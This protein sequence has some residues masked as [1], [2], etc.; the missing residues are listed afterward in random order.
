MTE[1]IPPNQTV[2]VGSIWDMRDEPDG[3]GGWMGLF[4]VAKIEGDIAFGSEEE[5]IESA[6]LANNYLKL[7]QKEAEKIRAEMKEYHK[8]TI[9]PIKGPNGKIMQVGSIW[10]HNYGTPGDNHT[11]I[12]AS[13]GDDTAWSDSEY[14]G[15]GTNASELFE[16]GHEI[17]IEELPAYYSMRKRK[18]L[19]EEIKKAENKHPTEIDVYRVYNNGLLV[20][21]KVTTEGKS[22]NTLPKI[23]YNDREAT[24]EEKEEIERS[25]REFREWAMRERALAAESPHKIMQKMIKKPARISVPLL[26]KAVI[27]AIP[28]NNTAIINKE[29]T[30]KAVNES[31]NKH[32]HNKERLRA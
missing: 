12:V 23:T 5:G 4:E 9:Q 15:W 21:Y 19:E 25:R 16:H 28:S 17:P 24:K 6:V 1:K 18:Y 2:E 27:T 13:L 11:F 14:Q 10:D 8:Q 29:I 3:N 20:D 22:Q 7:T 31:T 32:K 30:E 26:Q